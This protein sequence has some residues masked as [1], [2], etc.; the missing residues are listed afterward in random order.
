MLRCT[1]KNRR[2]CLYLQQSG[3][4]N[5]SFCCLHAGENGAGRSLRLFCPMRSPTWLA[6]TPS[7]SCLHGC[8]VLCSGSV[9]FP[10]GWTGRSRSWPSKPVTRPHSPEER[11][12]LCMLKLFLGSSLNLNVGKD[13]CDGMH[14]PWPVT[15]G[16]GSRSAASTAYSHGNPL[17]HL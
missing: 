6:A 1:S 9:L 15:P 3:F 14:C 13:G 16:P 10:G 8:I 5:R 4:E 7:H 17:L 11:T 12:A 2:H